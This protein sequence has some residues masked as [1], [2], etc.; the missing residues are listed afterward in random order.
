LNYQRVNKTNRIQKNR[1]KAVLKLR[2]IARHLLRQ[3]TETVPITER[4]D[5][6]CQE[7]RTMGR[8][9]T[10]HISESA[11]ERVHSLHDSTVC[12]IAKGKVHKK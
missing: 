12:C 10:Q 1:R 6:V 3:Y 4:T 9:L 11:N 7:Q 5:R 8:I 2:R